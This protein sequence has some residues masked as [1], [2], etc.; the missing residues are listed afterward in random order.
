MKGQ[1][2]SEKHKMVKIPKPYGYVTPRDYLDSN[3]LNNDA[4]IQGK[5]I[6]VLWAGI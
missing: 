2:Q 1:H 4:K 5:H 3:H 6:S